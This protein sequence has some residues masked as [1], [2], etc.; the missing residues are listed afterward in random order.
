M[1]KEETEDK[2]KPKP[3]LK[4]RLRSRDEDPDEEDIRSIGKD[5]WTFDGKKG[6]EKRTGA[7]LRSQ[8]R[9]K[10]VD[11][12]TGGR[13]EDLVN[14]IAGESADEEY[15][16]ER[17]QE[18]TIE[19]PSKPSPRPGFEGEKREGKK[20]KEENRGSMDEESPS[21]QLDKFEIRHG[22]P[23]VEGK[24]AED[25]NFQN[26]RRYRMEE[27]PLSEDMRPIG[28]IDSELVE[29]LKEHVADLSDKVDGFSDELNDI[30][31]EISLLVSRMDRLEKRE[32]NYEKVEEKLKELS[33]LYDI[34]SSDVS[35][36]IE[37]GELTH[38]S[39]EGGRR[40]VSAGNNI[41]HI[42]HL[43]HPNG[44]KSSRRSQRSSD[45]GGEQSQDDISERYDME[46]MID[47]ID[48]LY[49]KTGGNIQDALDYYLELGWIGQD[50][51][52]NILTYTE[53]MKL[54]LEYE[55]HDRIIGE[56]GDVQRGDK[57]WR[58]TPQDHK[59]SLRYI[60]AIKNGYDKG[61]GQVKNQDRQSFERGEN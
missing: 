58:L 30:D 43:N 47:W 25:P 4:S 41:D 39:S 16:V 3:S 56:D 29:D 31:E 55:E 8:R 13:K 61:K 23:E 17:L 42:N 44:L 26:R 38:G 27:R 50:L 19:K 53:G 15:R 45:D 14:E 22:M 11:E 12:I 10:R 20:E 49:T 28:S 24:S 57:D 7:D 2:Q 40:E 6:Y 32:V 46:A 33:A 18:Q 5:D 48:F 51:K 59:E 36:F 52:D 60:K 37:L 9:K 1:D 34:L 21:D 54:D 35:P